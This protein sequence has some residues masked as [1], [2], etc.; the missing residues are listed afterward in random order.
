MFLQEWRVRFEW[1]EFWLV[2]R[3]VGCKGGQMWKRKRTDE[4]AFHVDD[5]ESNVC[6]TIQP[7]SCRQRNDRFPSI[8]KGVIPFVSLVKG[9]VL[10]CLS[11]VTMRKRKHELR[12]IKGGRLSLIMHCERIPSFHQPFRSIDWKRNPSFYSFLSLFVQLSF[13][14]AKDKF[15]YRRLKIFRWNS[16]PFF[17]AFEGNFKDF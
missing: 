2:D 5:N 15:Q 13:T 1:I 6:T 3:Q 12:G 17:K 10:V 11:L 9:P 16:N 8:L 4:V 14:P 7:Q